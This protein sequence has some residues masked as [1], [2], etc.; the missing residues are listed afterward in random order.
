MT[1][2]KHATEPVTIVITNYNGRHILAETILSIR[3]LDYPNYKI[4][5]V[6]DGS[7][8]GSVQFVRE[9]F[10][11][12][13]IFEIGSNTRILNK[14]RNRGIVKADT[15][16]VFLTDND[17]TFEPDCLSLLVNAMNKLPNTAVCTPRILFAEDRNKIYTDGN[18]LH[19]ICTS[20][21]KNRNAEISSVNGRPERSIGCGIQLIDKIKAER[22]GFFDE[23][24]VMGWGDDG[25]FHHRLNL[26]GFKCYSVPE[27]LVY[28]KAIRSNP[29]IY[30]SI[31]N[32][33]LMIIQTYSLKTI[34]LISPALFVYEFVFFLFLIIK[35]AYREYF[36]AMND[37]IKNLNKIIE[38]RKK[39]QSTRTVPD[40]E[41]MDAGLIYVSDELAN[42]R[43]FEIG[44]AFLNLFFN[45]YWRAIK[46]FI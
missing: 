16:L 14:V 20:I 26:L 27:A 18:I 17:I 43:F 9:N 38:K 25:E 37:V 19:Y 39:I 45:L 33:W 3:K 24:Y 8:D 41:L 31:R 6:D 1:A 46:I 32:R 30:G 2:D 7:T 23:D 21:A 44:A 42:S 4:F 15:R 13:E 36:R 10:P 35:G 22:I 29:R 34:V 40:E 11:E 5:L 12:I 28:H